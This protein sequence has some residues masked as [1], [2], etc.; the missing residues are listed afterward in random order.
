MK[1]I[2]E[3]ELKISLF[4]R[5]GVICAGIIIL[6]GW[7]FDL[8]LNTNPFFNFTSYDPISL[9]E[10]VIFYFARKNWAAL[11]TLSGLGILILLPVIRVMLT[12]YLFLKQK[13]KVLAL[14]AFS[15]FLGLILSF[16]MGIEH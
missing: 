15:V 12:T 9:K 5:W 1:R 8:N 3:L 10:L 6:S 7:L 14:I 11:I 2:E 4:L 16:S 13:D